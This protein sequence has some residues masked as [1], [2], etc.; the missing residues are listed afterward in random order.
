M[1]ME[2][3]TA[4]SS[5]T[6][7]YD[8]E[9]EIDH[10]LAEEALTNKALHQMIFKYHHEVRL[11]LVMVRTDRDADG[12]T[13]TA[14]IDN[15]IV[16]SAFE[17]ISMERGQAYHTMVDRDHRPH[18]ALV[19]QLITPQ[20]VHSLLLVNI[21]IRRNVLGSYETQISY[22][23][24][25][26]QLIS[27]QSTTSQTKVAEESRALSMASSQHSPPS[28]ASTLDQRSIVRQG[29]HIAHH[30]GVPMTATTTG[31]HPQKSPRP[32]EHSRSPPTNVTVAALCLKQ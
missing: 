25:T 5:A 22:E 32:R 10:H 12:S 6:A 3:T 18:R 1:A 24:Y 27:T 17:A 8:P 2:P 20:V 4:S 28:R 7:D 13:Q 31:A 26:I 29:S 23:H 16:C 14:D 19:E 9:E 30:R 11:R 21:Q 15:H